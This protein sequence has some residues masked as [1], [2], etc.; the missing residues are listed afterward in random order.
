MSAPHAPEFVSMRLVVRVLALLLILLVPATGAFA[1]TDIKT[2]TKVEEKK[3][4]TEKPSEAKE[5]PGAEKEKPAA[6]E[7]PFSIVVLGDSLADGLWASIYRAYI[8][9]Q[10]QVAVKRY[11]VNS[12]GF[13]AHSFEGD[14]EKIAKDQPIDLVIFMVGANDRQRA[15]A[16]GTPREWAQFRTEKWHNIYRQNIQRFLGLIQEKKVA[17]VWVG[18]PV[19]RREDANEDA[20]MM[21]G[22]YRELAATHG[23]LFVDIT[24]ATANKDGE[25]D[26]YLEDD[27][28]RKRRFRA[29]DGV[30]FTDL[31][32]DH[33]VRHVWKVA[34]EKLPQF[35]AF[36]SIQGP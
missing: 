27:K 29:D 15:F 13:T 16:Q 5:K 2:E 22:I 34:R 19:M 12:A 36:W 3:P 18:L 7:R 30:H 8:R 26:P 32:Y 28:G 25:Y 9:S 10:K 33:V 21:N 17:L 20:K 14:F 1:E 4:D 23:A 24:A 35:Q 6:K 31:G 11:A